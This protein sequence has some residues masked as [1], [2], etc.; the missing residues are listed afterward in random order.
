MTFIKGHKFGKRFEK[1]F[2]PW[3]KGKKEGRI[4]VLEKMKISHLGP[5]PEHSKKMKGKIPYNKGKKSKL[6]GDKHWNWKGGIS[7]ERE[8][9]R[10]S[11]EL[12]LWKRA[13]F[14]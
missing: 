10:G 12:K 9:I 7:P 11:L 4:D 5:N 14:G 1:G 8:K 6:S 2:T 3:N 13:V